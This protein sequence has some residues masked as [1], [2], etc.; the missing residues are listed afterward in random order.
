MKIKDVLKFVADI[1]SDFNL[2]LLYE[3]YTTLNTKINIVANKAIRAFVENAVETIK[4]K[5]TSEEEKT[6]YYYLTQYLV[7]N[8][9]N[10]V[11]NKV[12]FK[13]SDKVGKYPVDICFRISKAEGGRSGT[14]REY[15]KCGRIGVFVFFNPSEIRFMEDSLRFNVAEENMR[16][17]MFKKTSTL[18]HEI[19]HNIQIL[20]GKIDGT[21]GVII[22]EIQTGLRNLIPFLKF[23]KATTTHEVEATLN[24]AYKL[25][26]E[27]SNQA[28]GEPE[29][30]SFWRYLAYVVLFCDTN[31]ELGKVVL[32]GKLG[33]GAVLAA[34]DLYFEK[35]LLIWLIYYY[36]PRFSKF[37]HILFKN[38]DNDGEVSRK[39]SK[40]VVIENKNNIDKFLQD[41]KSLDE[42]HDLDK[43]LNGRSLSVV[44]SELFSLSMSNKEFLISLI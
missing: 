10:A 7:N 22:R 12:L 36:I 35:F 8:G 28:T 5:D 17:V 44:E 41:I 16:D 3:R 37:K 33:L 40:E 1:N 43:T 9:I 42:L 20:T 23:L 39:F 25:Y 38:E 11:K 26:Y 29:K 15:L 14:T 32:S 6:D 30:G 13:Y 2:P 24:Q 27:R 31:N 4:P 18:V 21:Y 19:T 34:K